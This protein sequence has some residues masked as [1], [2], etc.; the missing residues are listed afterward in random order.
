[1]M[2]TAVVAVASLTAVVLAVPG[3]MAQSFGT[4]GQGAFDRSDG[5]A[6]AAPP[7]GARVLRVSEETDRVTRKLRDDGYSDIEFI[8]DQLPV[9]LVRACWRGQRLR[10]RLNRLGD[11]RQRTSL[12]QCQPGQT[13]RVRRA[14][15][16]SQARDL[17]RRLGYEAIS[18]TDR[19]P[20]LYTALACI[21]ANRYRVRMN[22]DGDIEF[23]ERAG[24]CFTSGGGRTGGG[25]TGG[26]FGRPDRETSLRPS[27]IRRL[28]RALGYT[29]EQFIDRR[30]PT[31]VV[32]VCRG[33]SRFRLE[34]DGSGRITDRAVIGQCSR[35]RQGFSPARVARLLEAR[36]YYEINYTREDR[37]VYEAT[38][39]RRA[40]EFEI[41]VTS[42]GDLLQRTLTGTCRAPRDGE[43]ISVVDLPNLR[44]ED[45]RDRRRLDPDECQDYFE[46]LLGDKTI[47]FATNSADID[48]G[49]FELLNNLIFVA[50]RCSRTTIEVAGHTDNVG[51][52]SANLELSKRRAAAVLK[53]LLETRVDGR[54]LEGRRLSAVGYGEA[55]PIADNTTSEGRARNRRIEFVGSWTQ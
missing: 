25:S 7:H 3:G 2:T 32:Q 23:R 18:L 47:N 10:L 53:Y 5:G 39:C 28:L 45:I 42:F 15:E 11:I 16:P 55:L 27:A 9:Y 29:R 17:L 34:L 13:E 12:G 8:D 14:I 50:Q 43:R 38:A 36:G 33:N 46:V 35:D 21:G 26:S 4:L 20:P 49:S 6:D 22:R 31:Y 52:E 24:R 51:S 40:R 37:P 54:R 30:L 1:M 19:T 44:L 48:R 41:R